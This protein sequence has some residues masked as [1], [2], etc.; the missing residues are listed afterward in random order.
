[1]L[2]AVAAFVHGEINAERGV[3]MAQNVSVC[4]T[5]RKAE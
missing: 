2:P 5:L 1:M 4:E 3:D